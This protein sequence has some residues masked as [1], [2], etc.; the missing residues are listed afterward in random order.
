LIKQDL[1]EVLSVQSYSFKQEL[2]VEYLKGKLSALGCTYE[3]HEGNIYV[4]KGYAEKY[5]CVVAHMDTV[6]DIESDLSIVEFDGALTG[7]NRHT[8]T[9]IGIGGDDKVG[10]FICLQ[11]LKETENIKV[12]FFRDEEVGCI[13]S[14]LADKAFFEDCYFVLEFDRRG[15]SDFV[16]DA[17]GVILSTKAFQQA[18]LPYVYKYGYS[19]AL[20]GGTDVQA[21][22]QLGIKCSMANLSCGYYNPHLDNEY[23]IIED[24]MN[25]LNLALEL[26]ENITE[27]YDFE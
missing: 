17:N 15:K 20:G 3:I 13:G 14:N 19:Y 10:V 27:S 9:Q 6:H 26:I 16:I 8:M 22:R 23:V 4:K 12:V 11:A 21:L 24:V 18:I 2:M 5:P 25:T 7:F 1:I